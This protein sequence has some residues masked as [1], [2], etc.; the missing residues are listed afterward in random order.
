MK[1][2]ADPLNHVCVLHKLATVGLFDASLHSGDEAVLIFEHT[3]NSVF[4]QLLGVLAISKGHLPEASFN[5]G[6]EM[7]FPAFKVREN[8]K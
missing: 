4:H 8:R 3:C 7:Y 1:Q 6:R 5:V 2:P